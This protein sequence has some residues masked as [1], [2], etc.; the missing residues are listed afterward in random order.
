V[1]QTVDKNKKTFSNYLRGIFKGLLDSVAAFLNR[2]GL[3]PNA[4]TLIGFLGNLI[5]AVVIATGRVS[6]GGIIILI[7]VPLDVVDGAMARL[8]GKVTPFGAF[9]DSVMDR[10]CE[11]VTFGGLIV[12]FIQQG[13]WLS[14]LIAYLAAAGSVMVSYTRARALSLGCD[15][16]I[17]LLSRLE[18]YIILIPALVFNLPVIGVWIIAV[19]ANFTAI[20]RILYVN[21]AINNQD[22]SE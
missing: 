4:V 10:Y 11:L 2:L 7:A 6:L 12:Y 17:G 15:V 5:G 3:T 8:R 21:K 16:Q 20:Q 19:L 9:F 13:D 22:N 18:R 14:C 1:E